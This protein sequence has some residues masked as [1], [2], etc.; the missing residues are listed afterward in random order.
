MIKVKLNKI[1]ILKGE[2]INNL[3]LN[4]NYRLVELPTLI[5]CYNFFI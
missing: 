3:M 1:M 5:N 2:C 4:R